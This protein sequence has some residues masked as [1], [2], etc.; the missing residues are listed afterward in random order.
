MKSTNLNLM[1]LL[2]FLVCC[3]WAY[4][5]PYTTAMRFSHENNDDG[6][7]RGPGVD[8]WPVYN[9]DQHQI[10]LNHDERLEGDFFYAMELSGNSNFSFINE[11]VPGDEPQNC[12]VKNTTYVDCTA[13]N[14]KKVPSTS[15]PSNILVFILNRNEINKLPEY[16]FFKYKLLQILEIQYNQIAQI[17]PLAFSG[18]SN[19]ERL[20]LYGNKLVMDSA[21]RRNAFSDNVFAPLK[22]LK[23]LR[24][25]RNNP[26]PNNKA[27]RYPDKALAQL[28]SLETLFLDGFPEPVFESGFANLTLLRYLSLNGYKDGYCQLNGLK[29]ETF[30]HMTSLQ[31]LLIR[32]CKL[33]GHKIEAGT[34]LPLK[35]LYSLDV[36]HNQDINVQFFD[37]LFY[38]NA[39][40][41]AHYK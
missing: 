14:L 18:L 3:T 35:K 11:E 5:A 8:E 13:G 2:T 29:N 20:D 37:R 16:A 6:E 31:N 39:A 9:Q 32:D 23:W 1:I 21:T 19:L 17:D 28:S 38:V 33:Q 30:R 22:N 40:Y 10:D 15:F 25:N 41:H 36:S 27:F 24:L 4:A 26:Q 34:F 12:R 7:V